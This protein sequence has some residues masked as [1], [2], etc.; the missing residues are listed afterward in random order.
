MRGNLFI[1]GTI[2]LALTTLLV[3][4]CAPA[5]APT[6][7]A[8]PTPTP[9]PAP[10]ATVTPT[11]APT[12]TPTPTPVLPTPT[13][14][15]VPTPTP[16]ATLRPTSTPTPRP[17]PPTSLPLPWLRVENTQIV[18]LSG[19]PV[20][21]RGVNHSGLEYDKTGAGISQAQLQYIQKNWNA[22]IIRL[23]FNQEWALSDPSYLNFMDQVID[24]ANGAKMYV[25]LDL[26]W[27]D[28]TRKIA[29]LPDANTPTLWANLAERYKNNPGVLFDIYNEPHDVTWDQWYAEAIKIVDVIRIK[30]PKALVVVGGVD[31]AYDLRGVNT[32]PIPQQNIVYSVHDYPWKAY[33]PR[34]QAWQ[35][36]TGQRAV[37]VGEWGGEDKDLSWGTTLRD[38][39][40]A[41]SVGYT[42]WSWVDWPP[43]T[44]DGRHGNYATTK[45]GNLV[46][47]DMLSQ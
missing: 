9:T 41:Q 14:T 43:L 21:L 7:S 20:T 37:F 10:T 24:W 17:T 26:H 23:P 42:A 12:L 28:T 31:W 47:Q 2:L 33:L 19:Q 4:A 6:P 5:A 38:Y 44:V 15:P 45:F 25:L 35:F 46:Q 39:M 40:R 27:L 3:S 11:P 18:T 34:D 32:K 13:P 8:V 30:H 36:L 22:N 29:P 1:K 16:T